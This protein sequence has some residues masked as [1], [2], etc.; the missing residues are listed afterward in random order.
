MQVK[1]LYADPSPMRK[2]QGWKSF[3]ILG[4]LG[5]LAYSLVPFLFEELSPWQFLAGCWS[6]DTIFTLLYHR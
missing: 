4:E 6:L 5:Y 1:G 3:P 2:T